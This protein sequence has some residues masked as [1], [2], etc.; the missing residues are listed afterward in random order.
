MKLQ[1][2]VVRSAHQSWLWYENVCKTHHS[3]S[4]KLIHTTSSLHNKQH[5]VK[6]E[7]ENPGHAP[8][9]KAGCDMKGKE[10]NSNYNFLYYATHYNHFASG[11][12][13]GVT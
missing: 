7:V 4:D 1:H 11:T 8:L 6:K 9:I 5:Y 2:Q 10:K 12:R 13:W 3:H